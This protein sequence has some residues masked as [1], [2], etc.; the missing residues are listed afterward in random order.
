MAAWAVPVITGTNA[1][2][3]GTSYWW[4]C[5]DAMVSMR[6][7]H[8]LARGYGLVWNP[9]QHVEGFSNPLWTGIMAVVHVAGVDTA[10]A[11]LVM[12][13]LTV[14][15]AAAGV[16]GVWRLTRELGGS[17][18]AAVAGVV[19]YILNDDLIAWTWTGAESVPLAVLLLLALSGMLRQARTGTVSW[20]AYALAG[21][22]ALMRSDSV[23]PA[24]L[25]LAV[26]VALHPHRKQVVLPTIL[27]LAAPAGYEVFRLIYYG[28]PYPNTAYLKV[29]GWDDRYLY[30]V[31]Y[32][33]LLAQRYAPVL[34]AAA[35]APLLC[36]RNRPVAA[37]VIAAVCYG[38]YVVCAGGD[39]FRNARF[40]VPII[41]V[42]IT[43]AAVAA[44]RFRPVLRYGILAACALPF[45]WRTT[46]LYPELMTVSAEDQENVMMGLSL[47]A[48]EYSGKSVAHTWAGSLFYFSDSPGIDLLGKCDPHIA[49]QTPAQAGA[50]PGHNKFDYDYSLGVL[51]PD[52]L[53][54][55]FTLPVQ[56]SVMRRLA[57]GPVAFTGQL[58]FNKE[59]QRHYLPNPILH[60]SHFTM[61]ARR[62]TIYD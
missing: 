10:H 35:A 17:T 51:K 62:L 9:G 25:V 58:Y 53:I 34:I 13:M 2:R 39:V 8:N 19:L 50:G 29:F 54:A 61:F 14:G 27:A 52:I 7:A 40:F 5:D 36:R 59:F 49:M 37:T 16:W 12:L 22:A 55:P 23:V 1:A 24:G 11:S 47:R 31:R 28:L 41:P 3:G 30:G 43:T 45:A 15:F 21:A 46:A 26:G 4:L 6:Y 32:A 33:W 18:A 20:G 42:L 48:P 38:V 44:H 57:T 56:D 60:G